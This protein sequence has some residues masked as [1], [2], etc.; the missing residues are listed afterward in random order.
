MKPFP[1]IL[2]RVAAL[3]F[4]QILGAS[5]DFLLAITEYNEL[6]EAEE[7]LRQK[8]LELIDK[9]CSG[10]GTNQSK[11]ILRQFANRISTNKSYSI[12]K[13]GKKVTEFD[14][15]PEWN[16][17]L[18][19]LEDLSLHQS[20]VSVFLN[21]FEKICQSEWSAHRSKLNSIIKNELI[22]NGLL[23]SSFSVY[24][25][26]QAYLLKDTSGFRKKELQTERTLWQYAARALSKASPFSTFTL[27]S[28]FERKEGAI[29]SLGENKLHKKFYLNNALLLH[30]QELL[31][32]IPDFYSQLILK[33]N[34]LINQEV[35]SYNFLLNSRNVESVQTL[36]RASLLD[37]LFESFTKN[38]KDRF[39]VVLNKLDHVV[40]SD[41]DAIETFLLELTQYGFLEFDWNISGNDSGWLNKLIAL[42]EEME[43]SAGLSKFKAGLVSVE[44]SISNFE[45][46]SAEELKEQ[47]PLIY[48][49]LKI[50][51][52]DLESNIES[53]SESDQMG[54][55]RFQTTGFPFKLE[56][57]IYQDA[58][59]IDDIELTVKQIEELTQTAQ[60]INE[61]VFPL[62][63][64]KF[65]NQNTLHFLETYTLEDEIDLF[66]FYTTLHQKLQAEENP[67]QSANQNVELWKTNFETLTSQQQGNETICLKI[68]ELQN[69]KKETGSEPQP[70]DSSNSFGMLVMPFEESGK[71]KY[72]LDSLFMGFGK[73]AGRFL[74][75]FDPVVSKR[76]K[77]WNTSFQSDALWMDLT[78]ASYFNANVH[79]D[80]LDWEFQS[81]GSQNRKDD[82]QIIKA[83][84]VVV[85]YDTFERRVGLRHK[86]AD[87]R[88]YSFDFGLEILDSRSP[89]YRMMCG[90]SIPQVS[91][92]EVVNI[93]NSSLKINI[94][95]GVF[96]LPRIELESGIVLQRK[97]WYIERNKLP[98]FESSE[99]STSRFL[100]IRDWLEKYRVPTQVFVTINPK[101]LEKNRQTAENR[102]SRPDDYKP[103][104]ID[105]NNPIACDIFWRDLKRV[106]NMLKI[107]ECLPPVSNY[108]NNDKHVTEYLIQWG[109]RN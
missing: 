59:R 106:P 7:K 48:K 94:G 41:K 89:M 107:Q 36:A 91:L 19:I 9:I 31:T 43:L 75:L 30:F 35:N 11:I 20:R 62:L 10:S 90:F 32:R 57:I 97:T 77:E 81:P 105:F 18:K 24:E 108:E 16:N 104:F 87:Q 26:A 58:S 1:Y 71:K 46:L 25:R 54:F 79:P 15:T 39:N 5:Q 101:E 47:I 34:P 23:A 56:K 22:Q 84:D 82:Q 83:K 67:F 68:E 40:D 65:Q 6:C 50:L 51:S 2:Q 12:E 33:L 70:F 88:I 52:E 28:L 44:S 63:N 42:L 73:M 66:T 8:S 45:N 14:D 86:I 99:N 76:I 69:L 37:Y 53:I 85:Y 3:P 61:I 27:L 21:E 96:L 64:P 72:F 38:P 102:K 80:F 4:R 92:R 95:S 93:M 103:K 74:H 29:I 78:D 13:L 17:L 98:H 109:V 49:E 100:K 55:K 60:Q